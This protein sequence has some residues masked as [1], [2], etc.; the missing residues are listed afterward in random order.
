MSNVD[1]TQLY[2]SCSVADYE[3]P[4]VNLQD[5]GV[6]FPTYLGAQA[7]CLIGIG[8]KPAPIA[9][10]D[11]INGGIDIVCG[12][13][14]DARG[15]LNMNGL[16]YEIADAVMFTN[17]FI[18]GIGAF[19][20]HIPG[21]IAASDVNADGISLS[22]ADLVYLIRVIVGDAQPYPKTAP[23]D[24][25]Y[26]FDQGVLNVPEEI[27][28]LYAVFAGNVTPT[29][30]TNLEML[31]GFDGVNTRCLIYP[32]FNHATST[33]TAHGDIVSCN[34]TIVSLEMATAAGSPVTPLNIPKNFGLNQNYPNPF[35]P[36][37][38]IS[39]S[40]PVASNYTLSIYN[41]TGQKVYEENGNAE[42]GVKTINVN[43][44]NRASGIYFYKVVAGNFTDTKKMM[45]L[46]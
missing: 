9:D 33:A 28:A 4:L 20:T 3:N 40:L 7:E 37:T 18:A 25:K 39:F 31:T 17:Y 12:D 19:G 10:I 15:D 5:R 38:V 27:G 30:M 13:S 29:N 2:V 1:G 16:G 46:K 44:S 34:A 45:L 8:N 26:T 21:S 41:V 24:V 11:F 43:M 6:G 23:V 35:N 42:A 32:N 36:T 14:I 22:V